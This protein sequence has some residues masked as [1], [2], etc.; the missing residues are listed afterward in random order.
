MAGGWE[1]CCGTLAVCIIA[2]GVLVMTIQCWGE[3]EH[4]REVRSRYDQSELPIVMAN[5]VPVPDRGCS[6]NN[7]STCFGGSLTLTLQS[8]TCSV[9]VDEQECSW[10]GIRR[11]VDACVK[12]FL[13]RNLTVYHRWHTNVV[14]SEGNPLPDELHCKRNLDDPHTIY[15]FAMVLTIGIACIICCVICC[16]LILA[17][18]E[19]KRQETI[20]ALQDQHQQPPS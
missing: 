17:H 19:N 7:H 15:V 11:H 1:D 12:P 6:G 8:R 20:D 16:Y 14:D 13:G 10:S 9:L 4:R 3:Y 18:N 5:S 2:L